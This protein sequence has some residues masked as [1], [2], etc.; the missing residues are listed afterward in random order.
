MGSQPVSKC[1]DIHV[2]YEGTGVMRDKPINF[3][4]L[5]L[6][7]ATL[8]HGCSAGDYDLKSDK[9]AKEEEDEFEEGRSSETVTGAY[10]T[11]ANGQVSCHATPGSSHNKV[12][13]QAL[14]GNVVAENIEEGLKVK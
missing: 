11:F 13:C 7:S 3:F 14:A 5:W 6:I 10:L 9:N 8:L 4:G 2:G 1:A 12:N